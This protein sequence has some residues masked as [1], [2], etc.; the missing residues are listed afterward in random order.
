MVKFLFFFHLGTGVTIPFL[1]DWGGLSYAWLMAAEACF[2]FATLL[3]EVP[4]GA[5]A[6]R[7]GR[8]TSMITA[9]LVGVVAILVYTWSPQLPTIV[10]GTVLFSVAAALF[11]GADSALLYDT[12]RRLDRT[13]EAPRLFARLDSVRLAGFM[14]GAA[15]G[16]V[17]AEHHGVV[18]PQFWRWLPFSLTSV[19]ALSLFEPGHVAPGGRKVSWQ[20]LMV[21]GVGALRRPVL[22]R[23][24]L[25][26][27]APEAFLMTVLWAYQPLAE[28]VGIGIGWFGS[29]HAALAFIQILM[30]WRITQL[31]ALLGGRDRLLWIGAVV[32]GLALA[33]T[34]FVRHP[35]L[36][37]LALLTTAGLGLIRRPVVL[38]VLNEHIEDHQRATVLSAVNMVRMAG[39]GCGLL[40]MGAGF[41][42][43]IPLTMLTLGLGA[44]VLA[45]TTRLTRA[46][47]SEP[48]SQTC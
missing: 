14:L 26:Y 19:V 32:A 8:R 21:S 38:A 15:T 11:S 22:R 16:S 28:G 33:S 36:L 35:A 48:L 29:I 10:L 37:L 17:I 31:Q 47:G 2:M 46:P 20:A 41:D 13:Q 34:A 25:H 23:L 3:L 42:R 6:D 30:L 24:V 18:A 39:I 5:F 40:V 9:G 1:R 4:S 12:L 27:A 44:A 43:S 7:F 45:S